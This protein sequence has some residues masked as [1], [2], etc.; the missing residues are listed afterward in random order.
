MSLRPW[1]KLGLS[2]AIQK[3]PKKVPAVKVVPFDQLFSIAFEFT[4]QE[5][6]SQHPQKWL[7]WQFK[8][9]TASNSCSRYSLVFTWWETPR[10]GWLPSKSPIWHQC[11][12]LVLNANFNLVPRKWNCTRRAHLAHPTDWG[13]LGGQLLFARSEP[14][15]GHGT[16]T[17]TRSKPNKP[18]LVHVSAQ[19]ILSE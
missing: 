19:S 3:Q 12:L 6:T 2:C 4:V 11:S 15:A 9:S 13:Y 18:E 17:S 16:A 14:Q 1:M 10:A 7:V 8:A 5:N